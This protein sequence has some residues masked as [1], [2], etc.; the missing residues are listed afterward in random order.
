[1]RMNRKW[2]YTAALMTCGALMQLGCSN[3]TL[4]TTLENGII[5]SSTSFLASFF[6]ALINVASAQATS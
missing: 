2:I 4:R 3:D 6:R 5:D 1:M